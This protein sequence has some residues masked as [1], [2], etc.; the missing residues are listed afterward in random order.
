MHKYFADIL[1]EFP[2]KGALIEA[3]ISAYRA[4]FESKET[5]ALK[6]FKKDLKSLGIDVRLVHG[7]LDGKKTDWL[8]YADSFLHIIHDGKGFRV[9][10][11]DWSPEDRYKTRESII[12][13][14]KQCK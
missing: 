7:T 11:E 3:A 8:D 1:E 12:E 10:D 9:F 6:S 14:L 4:I 2:Q 13:L 5:S